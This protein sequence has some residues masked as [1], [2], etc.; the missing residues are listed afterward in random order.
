MAII[1]SEKK[2]PEYSSV[3]SSWMSAPSLPHPY[4]PPT[5]P[6]DDG[7]G[8]TWD[9]WYCPQLLGTSDHCTKSPKPLPRPLFHLIFNTPEILAALHTYSRV[10]LNSFEKAVHNI[11]K[12]ISSKVLGVQNSTV[13]HPTSEVARKIVYKQNTL[14]LY[15]LTVLLKCYIP[16]QPTVCKLFD[17]AKCTH[18]LFVPEPIFYFQQ[19]SYF[20]TL[21][22]LLVNN[23][24]L[25]WSRHIRFQEAFRDHPNNQKQGRTDKNKIK[26]GHDSDSVDTAAIIP[27]RGRL[28][29]EGVR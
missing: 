16:K 18:K 20:R 11:C 12:P 24:H 21:C 10:H 2:L 29:I 3:F 28:G 25:F 26:R 4:R 17:R 13:K 6:A 1:I 27:A 5:L 15:H 7:G 23:V 14:C 19:H 22:N 8:R 9:S